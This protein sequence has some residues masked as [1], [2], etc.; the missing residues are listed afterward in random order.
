MESPTQ[1]INLLLVDDHAM[2]REGLA[3]T[4]EREPDFKIVGQCS[5]STEALVQIQRDKSAMI[6]LLDVDLGTHRALEFVEAAKKAGFHGRILVVTAGI[7]GA[8]AVNLIQAGVSGILNKR[9]STQVLCETIRKVA[10]GEACL[11]N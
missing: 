10:A 11:E 5:S 2:F 8:E 9:Q 7:S 1:T 3:R 4:F 6:V